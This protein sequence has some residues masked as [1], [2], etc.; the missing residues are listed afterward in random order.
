MEPE[1]NPDRKG[2]YKLD[3]SEIIN[4]KTGSRYSVVDQLDENFRQIR[5]FRNALRDRDE[6]I[7][8]LHSSIR[9]R[10]EVIA[11]QN[12]KLKLTNRLRPWIY[13]IL[14][15]AVAKLGDLF[16]ERIFHLHY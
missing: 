15:G 2:Q 10:D 11:G 12:S 7:N 1:D 9:R 6:V 5:L 14:G 16:I 4:L 3:G 13:G 8:E